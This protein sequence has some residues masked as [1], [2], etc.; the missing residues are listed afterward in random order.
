MNSVG[1]ADCVTW[2]ILSKDPEK[3]KTL[4]QYFQWLW[5]ERT[6]GAELAQ[7]LLMESRAIAYNLVEQ[8]VAHSIDDVNTVLKNGFFHLYGV[9]DP[10][11]QG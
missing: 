5:R 7:T 9:D 2:K 11:T 3:E 6:L 8:G 1:I 4:S 10:F